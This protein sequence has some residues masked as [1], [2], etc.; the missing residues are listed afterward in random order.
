MATAATTTQPSIHSLNHHLGWV[1]LLIALSITGCVSPQGPSIGTAKANKTIAQDGSYRDAV[2]AYTERYEI[3]NQFKT[4]NIVQVTLLHPTLV[5]RISQRHKD[6]FQ[7][8]KEVFPSAT[9]KFSFLV[10]LYSRDDNTSDLKDK[11]YWN[12]QITNRGNVYEP[13]V[14]QE[15]KEKSRW[16]PFFPHIKAWSREY[17]IVFDVPL[18]DRR[19]AAL[20]KPETTTLKI[21]S[22]TGKIA[23]PYPY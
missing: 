6:L 22:A 15:L 21:S 11:N 8:E 9:D 4:D 16:T 14:T 19:K 3:I 7:D 5:R 13:V 10:S 2:D 17:L 20:V 23:I 1:S 12:V 18:V